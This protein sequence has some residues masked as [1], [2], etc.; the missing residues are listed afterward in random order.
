MTACL[1]CT[2]NSPKQQPRLFQNFKRFWL[3]LTGNLPGMNAMTGMTPGESGGPGQCMTLQQGCSTSLRGNS[4]YR[5]IFQ[6][7][8][9][10]YPRPPTV[11]G[12]EFLSFWGCLG[13]A[14]GSGYRYMTH[15]TY[16]Y[17]LLFAGL[18][19]RLHHQH[20]THRK[21]SKFTSETKKLWML[22]WVLLGK[23]YPYEASNRWRLR[24]HCFVAPKKVTVNPKMMCQQILLGRFWL[25]LLD[26]VFL[27]SKIHIPLKTSIE[28][29]QACLGKDF[30][31]KPAIV[32]V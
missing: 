7:N 18:S 4:N 23:P 21:R 12:V 6:H 28:H 16:V 8:P 11:Y 1:L 25:N 22:P 9:G 17:I 2:S 27:P 14:L 29:E 10:T 13:Y 19:F 15:T 5:S 20:V 31:T 30:R 32:V 24:P 3:F 26:V